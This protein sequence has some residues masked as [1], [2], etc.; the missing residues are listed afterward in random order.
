MPVVDI[1]ESEYDY[2]KYGY[3]P[4][5]DY[6]DSSMVNSSYTFDFSMSEINY[7]INYDYY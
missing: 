3:L 5:P 7:E 4:V 1:E 2:D 6:E